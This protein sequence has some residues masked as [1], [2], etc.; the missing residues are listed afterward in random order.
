MTAFAFPAACSSGPA[1]DAGGGPVHDA[2]VVASFN[3]PESEVVAEI[4][5]QSLERAG[6][7]VHRELDLGPRELVMPALQQSFVDLVP[8]YV[9]SAL[10]SFGVQPRS[11]HD[12]SLVTARNDLQHVLGAWN[13]R[14]LTP[15]AAQNQN[16]VVVTRETATRDALASISDLSGRATAMTLGGPAEC[17]SRPLCLQGL[18]RVYGLHFRSFV[19]ID[20]QQE[21]VTALQE[22]TIDAAVMFTTDGELA[23]DHLVL[24]KDDRYLQPPE[25]ILPVVSAD[26]IARYGTRLVAALDAVSAQLTTASLRVLN[27]R[28]VVGGKRVADEARGWLAR[29]TS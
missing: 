7:P 11:E 2:V 19:P 13:L 12:A 10:A 21:E 8:E 9:G 29:H 20:D 28:V 16:G 26:A 15:S 18:E 17:P 4:Y 6:V 23:S 27:W 1:G 3:F 5:A 14:V 25:N 24:L 22:H